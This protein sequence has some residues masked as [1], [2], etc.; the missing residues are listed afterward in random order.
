MNMEKSRYSVELNRYKEK[1]GFSFRMGWTNFAIVI[2]SF[3]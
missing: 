3:F 1:E 2:E